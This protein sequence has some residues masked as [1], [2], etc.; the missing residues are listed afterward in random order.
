MSL[1]NGFKINVTNCFAGNEKGPIGVICSDRR[2]DFEFIWQF[3]KK[4]NFFVII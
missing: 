1:Y 4:F 2:I 3:E